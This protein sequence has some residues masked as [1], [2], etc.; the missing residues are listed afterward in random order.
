V[1]I[2]RSTS[3]G[4]KRTAH[5]RPHA[6]P[7]TRI[8]YM[9]NK[10]AL[11]AEVAVIC[12]DL[13][14][15][16]RLVDL[17]GG[18]CNV[19]GAVA[20][21]ARTVCVNDVQHY[22]ELAARCVIAAPTG[23]P[24]PD[25]VATTLRPAFISN[26]GSLRKRFAGPLRQERDALAA[27][28]PQSLTNGESSWPNAATDDD[29]AREVAALSL[30]AEVPYRLCT[31]TFAWGYFGLAQ[32]IDLD[33]LRFAIDTG[34]RSGRFTAAD[35][36]WLR[37][38]MLQTAS[39]V[40]STAG[41]FAQFLRPSTAAATA[42]I[43]MCRRRPIWDWF[44]EDVG[45]L[46]P[47]GSPSWRRRNRVLRGDALTLVENLAACAPT[48]PGIFYADP[49]YSKEHYSRFYHVLE[50]LER[51]DYPPAIGAGR[52]RP[53]RFHSDFAIATKVQEAITRLFAAVAG[54]HSTLIFSYP[55]TGL[56]TAGRGI[57]VCDLLYEHFANVR[58]AVDRAATHSTLGGRH[59]H[60]TRPVREQ[61]WVAC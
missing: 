44:I 38:A 10:R 56:L 57:E 43:V 40:A 50:T 45:A 8:R 15:S 11:A 52:Y 42:R 55:S 6:P 1:S 36:R 61:I 3:T 2:S 20:P 19:A 58:L 59:G 7:G 51:Y 24:C 32:S 26:R 9:G 30:N 4:A 41:H 25:A 28:T 5:P 21:A 23:P 47:Y 31:L 49:P 37:L 35:A 13:E 54:M 14:P 29:V 33:S 17:F 18:M 27:A 39:R 12:Q 60:S 16:L 34:A 53:D 22:A 48:T 46:M